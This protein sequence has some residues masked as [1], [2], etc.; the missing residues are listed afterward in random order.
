MDAQISELFRLLQNL[1][2]FGTVAQVENG[3]VRVK[4]LGND[5]EESSAPNL[6]NWIRWMSL[7]AGDTATWEQPTIGEQVI[8]FSPNGETAGGVALGGIYCDLFP[9]PSNSPS[10]HTTHYP[11]GAVIEYDHAV[12]S[13]TATLPDGSSATLTAETAT[14][15]A[16]T[17]TSNADTTICTGDLSVKGNFTVDGTSAL[18]GGVNAKAGSDG[19]AAM[20]IQGTL[21]ATEEVTAN[22]ISLTGHKHGGVEKGGGVTDGPQ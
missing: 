8:V 9:A 2:R 16:T 1:I 7:R 10:L 12:H 4:T 17:V 11:D 6:T 13:L 19:S 20:V 15:N 22:G 5:D 18:N 14:V 21:N 3:R